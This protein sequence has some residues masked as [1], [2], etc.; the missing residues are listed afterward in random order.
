MTTYY[1]VSAL[2]ILALGVSSQR[3]SCRADG[4]TPPDCSQWQDP[5]HPLYQPHQYNCS[6]FWQ[7][8][9][10]SRPC[11][12]ECPAIS[13]EMGGG[14]LSFN[15]ELSV[16]DWPF[17]VD[18]TTVVPTEAPPATTTTATPTPACSYVVEKNTRYPSIFFNIDGKTKTET[19]SGCQDL[20]DS[21]S[22][23]VAWTWNG[24]WRGSCFIKS[25]VTGEM[26]QIGAVSARKV[27]Q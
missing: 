5:E 22:E 3:Q 20:C 19:A 13:E 23:C 9:P 21:Y 10:D 1:T 4:S 18:C 26:F 6:L 12:L 7:C 24:D 11:L 27:C 14:S 25:K 2:L 8:T 17:N 15:P 16:C